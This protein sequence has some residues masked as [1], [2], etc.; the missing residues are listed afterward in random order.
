MQGK[1]GRQRRLGLLAR[2]RV[3]RLH[4]T[5][6][7]RGTSWG[8][9]PRMSSPSQPQPYEPEFVLV[10]EQR[11]IRAGNR[12][13]VVTR[14][15]FQILAM[16]VAEP[17]RVFHRPELVERGIGNLVTDRTVDAHIKELRR[18]LGHYGTRIETVRGIGYRFTDRSSRAE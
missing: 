12:G 1:V 8:Y 14:T 11:E 17:G 16:L 13:F 15:Q 18:K 5:F 6:F 9:S 10:P 7:L 3:Y 4:R 2:A